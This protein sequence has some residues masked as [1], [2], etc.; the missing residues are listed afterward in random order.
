MSAVLCVVAMAAAASSTPSGEE[1]DGDRSS[2]YEVIV[3]GHRG[4]DGQSGQRRLDD[5][6]PG[7]G[8]AVE[9]DQEKGARPAD[10]LP[11]VISRIPGATVRSMG[12]LGQYSAVS[13][14]GSSS[15]Q[16]AVFIDG[17]PLGTSV[18]GLVDLSD[19][20]L[21]L[22][23]RVEVFR[24]YVPV[25]FGSAAI[26]G[27]VNLVGHREKGDGHRLSAS[28]GG[29]SYGG[30]ELRIASR[31]NVRQRDQLALRLGYA[32]ADGDFD[33]L[34]VH[35]TPS[36]PDRHTMSKRTNNG[37]ARLAGQV[38]YHGSHDRWRWRIQEIV[39]FKHQEIP[40]TAQRQSTRSTLGTLAAQTICNVRRSSFLAPGGR[41]EL[42]AGF[43]FERRTFRDPLG[44]VGIEIDD[45]Q[46]DIT[47]TY[48]SPRLR[49]PLW[50]G[51]FATVVA[52]ARH[53]WTGVDNR[54]RIHPQGA[55]TTG[56]ASRQRLSLGA[57]IELQQLLF[58]DRLAIVP[59]LRLERVESFFAVAEG[60]G[61]FADTGEDFVHFAVA[62]RVGLRAKLHDT[63]EIRASF[64]RYFRP[65][66]M[67]ELFGDRGFIVGNEGLVS[68]E[69]V[70]VDG[71]FV[72]DIGAAEPFG[73]YLQ[74]AAFFHQTENL[75]QWQ[76]AG[77]VLRSDN[78]EG[79]TMAGVELG[80]STWLWHG[81]LRAQANYT[82]LFTR[83]D[84][85]SA[86][87]KGKQLPGRP[88][89]EAFTRISGGY[90]FDVAGTA[91][92]PRFF[93]SFEFIAGNYLDPSG[94]RLVPARALHGAG[95]EASI[96]GWLRMSFEVRNLLDRRV[97]AWS[98]VAANTETLRVPLSDF[99]GYPL[100]GRSFWV[101]LSANLDQA[102]DHH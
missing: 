68:E 95:L 20:P 51:A 2:D 65:P 25:S 11:E 101:S 26:G 94:R 79:A 33:F 69:G 3:H 96:H 4:E 14:R 39:L 75:I 49:L 54:V 38:A 43:G 31:T 27:A 90:P 86:H 53:E 47:D 44:E 57:G 84:S 19:V 15:Q 28:A 71:G 30:R 97:T 45:E 59:A 63:F 35:G 42:V 77:P 85:R 50:T 16:V 21:D 80:L 40:G 12:G 48:L 73:S 64:G 29:G 22:L 7:F 92:E 76:Q 88:E 41:L 99:I 34:D 13:L 82:Y 67:L 36:L 32:A 87:T 55:Q 1:T 56:D 98:P 58:A 37:Y 89:H 17:I 102:S 46:S 6:T 83:N 24:G 93:Y 18:G 91:I 72:A 8:T 23:E 9:L 78:V 10:A 5:K 62:P 66:N 70:G 74:A 52:D 61:E 81:R 100:P 60:Q